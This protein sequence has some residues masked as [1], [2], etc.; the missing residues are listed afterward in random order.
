MRRHRLLLDRTWG[1]L[2]EGLPGG[3]SLWWFSVTYEKNGLNGKGTHQTGEIDTC[4]AVKKYAKHKK[5]NLHWLTCVWDL[6]AQSVGL[7]LWASLEN[8]FPPRYSAN[9][10]I[11]VCIAHAEERS[12]SGFPPGPHTEGWSG[13]AWLGE[14]GSRQVHSGWGQDEGWPSGCSGRPRQMKCNTCCKTQQTPGA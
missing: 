6:P 2:Q 8:H 7:V 3:F 1:S 13:E 11:S 9:G 10:P 4:K 5:C 14:A 12:A